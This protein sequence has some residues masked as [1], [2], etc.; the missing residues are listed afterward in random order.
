MKDIHIRALVLF[1]FLVNTT[2]VY[3][4]QKNIVPDKVEFEELSSGHQFTEGPYWLDD[5][6]LIFSDIPANTIF[7]WTEKYGTRVWK[8]PSGHS[9]GITKDN[10]G[11][12]ILAQHDRRVSKI[13]PDGREIPLATH[14]KGARLN[15][16]NDLVVTKRGIIYFTD[17]PFGIEESEQET[18]KNAVYMLDASGNVTQLA[19]DFE[20]PNGVALSPNEDVLYVNDS[21]RA[22]IKAFDINENGHLENERIFALMEDEERDGLPDGMKVDVHGNIYSTGAG[23]LWI[24]TPEG[25]LIDRI[26]TP[27]VT[28]NLAWG[29]EELNL[30]FLTAQES[31]YRITLNTRGIIQR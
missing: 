6:T 19:T 13:L 18:G 17:P 23:G 11:N 22:H 3:A 14:Y 25:E 26:F 30:L 8:R 24:F 15:S 9:N 16:P 5:G 21:F 4:Q 7:E 31:I 27:K 10:A 12:I 1:L 2:M 29:G 28:T 20:R